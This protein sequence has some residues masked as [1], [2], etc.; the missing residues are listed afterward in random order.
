MAIEAPLPEFIEFKKPRKYRAVN[1]LDRGACGQTVQIRDEEMGVDLVAK[2]F[3]PEQSLV[4]NSDLNKLL[5]DKFRE[6]ARILFRVNHPNVVR[7]FNYYDYRKSGTSY[8]VMEFVDGTNILDFISSNPSH[9]DKVFEKVLSGFVYLESKGILHRDIRP[10]N[11]LV[12]DK[13]EPKIIDF[14][15]GKELEISSLDMTKSISLNWR[16]EIPP[17]F[18]FDKPLYDFQT[19]VYFLGKLFQEII[20]QTPSIEFKYVAVLQ[21]M[22]ETNRDKRF[23]SFSKIWSSMM[24]GQ[25][26]E[27]NFTEDEKASYRKFSDGLVSIFGKIDSGAVYCK[28]ADEMIDGLDDL[29]NGAMLEEYVYSLDKLTQIFVKGR[30][31]Y[32]NERSF[33]V[34]CLKDFLDMVKNLSKREKDIVLSHIH[35]RLDSISRQDFSMDDIPF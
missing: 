16:Y 23:P 27:I 14:G 2:K 15:F 32:R 7:V 18:K 8:I 13:G 1:R 4:E 9:V 10:K 12:T 35:V 24:S 33:R 25:I 3:R 29:Y 17:E 5:L 31:S 11:I 30:L 20:D 26:A 19:D 28:D 21:G 34:A 22:W 6:E